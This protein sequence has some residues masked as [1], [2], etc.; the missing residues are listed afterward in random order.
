LKPEFRENACKSTFKG[1]R[2]NRR[3][4]SFKDSA[5]FVSM[6]CFSSTRPKPATLQKNGSETNAMKL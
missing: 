1:N 3:Q 6:G 4:I 2:A 5:A